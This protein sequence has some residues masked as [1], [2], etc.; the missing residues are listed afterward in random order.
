MTISQNYIWPSVNLSSIS[1]RLVFGFWPFFLRGLK[2]AALRAWT[3]NHPQIIVGTCPGHHPQPI[4]Q[5]HV[6]KKVEGLDP[7]PLI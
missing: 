7:P 1:L 4:A 2:W 3:Q 6:F 5:N